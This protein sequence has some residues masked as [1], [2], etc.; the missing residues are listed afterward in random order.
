MLKRASLRLLAAALMFAFAGSIARADEA[1]TPG[2]THAD[3]AFLS[4]RCRIDQRDIDVI[5]KLEPAARD[6][7]REII[8]LRRCEL[9][10]SFSADR[11]YYRILDIKKPVPL[12]PAGWFKDGVKYLTNDEYKQYMNIM[13]NAPW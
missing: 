7:L 1:P 13:N 4:E 3:I 10:N 11:D 9:L 12:P 2:L 8:K 6:S 5:D